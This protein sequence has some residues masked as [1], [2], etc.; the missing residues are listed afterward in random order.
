MS[1]ESKDEK[2]IPPEEKHE[3]IPPKLMR[4]EE[5]PDVIPDGMFEGISEEKLEEK[6]EDKPEEK[7]EEKKNNPNDYEMKKYIQEDFDKNSFFSKAI[8]E[9]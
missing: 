4:P 7:K 9:K 5:I 8:Y 3:E 2:E 6:K 1:E